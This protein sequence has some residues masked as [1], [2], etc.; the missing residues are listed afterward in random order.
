MTSKDK[1][2]GTD[3]VLLT[4]NKLF[5]YYSIFLK[6][7]NCLVLVFMMKHLIHMYTCYTSNQQTYVLNDLYY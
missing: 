2:Q 6:K 1:E 5:A 4:S 3:Y 7:M